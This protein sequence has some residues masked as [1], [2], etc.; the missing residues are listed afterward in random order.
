[1]FVFFVLLIALGGVTIPVMCMISYVRSE[2]DKDTDLYK[3]IIDKYGSFVSGFGAWILIYCF[4]IAI[5]VCT[6][7]SRVSTAIKYNRDIAAIEREKDEKKRVGN[8][9]LQ[10]LKEVCKLTIIQHGLL[11]IKLKQ[12]NLSQSVISQVLW[13]A[14]S[15]DFFFVGFGKY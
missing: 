8:G 7:F 4:G 2:C 11:P 13:V 3:L 6:R 15:C 5:S 14:T 1:M 10:Q 12:N 9:E